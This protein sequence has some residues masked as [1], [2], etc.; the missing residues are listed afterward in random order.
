MD[1]NY[2][3]SVEFKKIISVFLI[4]LVLLIVAVFL[5]YRQSRL[6]EMSQK[7]SEQMQVE[8]ETMEIEKP[9]G[10][11]MILPTTDTV[12]LNEEFEVTVTLSAD[13]LVLDGA[14]AIVSF[15]P[16][17][18]EA[19][20]IRESSLFSSYPRKTTDNSAGEVKIT[21]FGNPDRKEL[22]QES[23][24]AYITFR[25]ISPGE[26]MINF[27]FEPGKT[28]LSVMVEKDTSKNVLGEVSGGAVDI[29]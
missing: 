29:K 17:K 27:E 14:D 1:K 5:R 15:D 24:F 13:G 18:L 19:V 10:R 21:G 22:E 7:K 9:G 25:A 6:L 2:T 20:S 12:S 8:Q 28:N 3:G 26:A 11:M 4:L 23:D 16:E